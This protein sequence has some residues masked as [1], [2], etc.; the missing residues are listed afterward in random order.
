MEVYLIYVIETFS[1]SLIEDTMKDHNFLSTV[2]CYSSVEC[3][4]AARQLNKQLFI[5]GV[6]RKALL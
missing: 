4:A 2:G 3:V 6:V 1:C 5:A